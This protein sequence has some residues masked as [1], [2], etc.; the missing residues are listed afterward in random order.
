MKAIQD[1]LHFWFEELSRSDWFKKSDSLDQTIISRFKDLYEKAKCG[2]LFKWRETP[3]GRLAE[4]IILDQFSRNMFRGTSKAFEA[5]ILALTLAQE[6]VI[7][8]LDQKFDLT[9]RAFIYMP[10][11]HSESL[12]I[13]EEAMKLFSQAG[14]KEN[15]EFEVAHKKVIEKFGR[16]PHRN[17]ILGRESTEEEKEYLKSNK[18]W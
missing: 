10:Y 13:H 15:L 8:K 16:Y 4:I 5:D 7:Q 11:M 6:M 3:E 18:G 9:K 2:E 14:L 1:V 17:A 12:A